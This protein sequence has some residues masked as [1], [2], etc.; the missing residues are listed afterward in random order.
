MEMQSR[1]TDQFTLTGLDEALTYLRGDQGR[2]TATSDE[3][4]C[5]RE[6]SID[7]REFTMYQST[8]REVRMSGRRNE[9]LENSTIEVDI[10]KT[11]A[12]SFATTGGAYLHT[13]PIYPLLKPIACTSLTYL[14]RYGL[15]TANP[16]ESTG[17]LFCEHYRTHTSPASKM[18]KPF[19]E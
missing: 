16:I 10:A 9:A 13:L 17:P 4:H 3:A 5:V 8:G 15:R 14:C 1:G 2:K 11:R 6:I 19:L 18:A 7:Q 12:K